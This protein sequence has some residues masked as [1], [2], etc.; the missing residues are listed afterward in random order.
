MPAPADSDENQSNMNPT[1]SPVKKRTPL[2][3]IPPALARNSQD[4]KRLTAAAARRAA[5][6]RKL[7]L[8]AHE[9]EVDPSQSPAVAGADGVVLKSGKYCCNTCGNKMKNKKTLIKCHNSKLHPKDPVKGSAYLRQKA[10]NP[11]PCRHCDKVCSSLE[12]LK[13][14]LKQAHAE[15]GRPTSPLANEYRPELDD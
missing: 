10:R 6:E 9:N 12:M 3:T 13:K 8:T 1:K 5:K 7:L 15:A 11:S 4:A 14:H 2:P